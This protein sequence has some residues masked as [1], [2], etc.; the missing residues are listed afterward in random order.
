VIGIGKM[1]DIILISVW[2]CR[3]VTTSSNHDYQKKKICARMK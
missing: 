3:D 2:L 1:I